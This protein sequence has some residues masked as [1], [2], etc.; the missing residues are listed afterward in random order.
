MLAPC[1]VNNGSAFGKLP[2][3]AGEQRL[4]PRKMNAS[5][6]KK[7]LHVIDDLA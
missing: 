5:A 6:P 7:F 3:A 4:L 1:P 2:K